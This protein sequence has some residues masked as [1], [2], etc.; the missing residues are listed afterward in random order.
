MLPPG[1]RSAIVLS[2]LCVLLVV[3]GVWGFNAATEPFPGKRDAPQCVGT[4]VAAG[5]KVFPAQVTVSVYNA[6]KRNGLASRTMGLFR[7]AGFNAGDTGNAPKDADVAFAAIWTEQPDNPAVQLVAS[8]LGPDV[9]IEE[10]DGRG[11]GVTV[12][13]GDGFEALEK[14]VKRV[15]A[16]EDTRICSPPVD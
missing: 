7:D 6:G 16:E 12:L 15:V 14:G 1:L 2:A 13:V 3:V 11:S 8:R 10:R 5:E 9:V 4:P